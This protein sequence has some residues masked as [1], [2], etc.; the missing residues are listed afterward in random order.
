[1]HTYN[2]LGLMSG[3]SLDGLDMAYCQYRFVQQC[4]EFEIVKTRQ[5]AY[6]DTRRKELAYAVTL[7]A[8]E[9]LGLHHRYGDWLG[10]QVRQFVVQEQLK[11]DFVASHGHTVHHRPDLG[12]TFQAGCGQHLSNRCGLPVVCDF[13]S[14]DLALG[15]QG[16]PLVPMGDRLLFGEYD[17]C[18][19][20]GGISNISF[21]D[22]SQRIAY[23]IG[24]ANMLLNYLCRKIQQPFDPNGDIARSGTCNDELL[25]KLNALPYY[26]SAYPKSTGYEW[27]AKEI[28]PLAE[29]SADTVPNLL[30][31]AVHHIAYTVALAL[32]LH[33]VGRFMPKVLVSGGGAFNT[34]LID[35][36]RNYLQD[37]AEIIIPDSQII[38]YKEALI[39]GFL[40]VLRE[41]KQVNTLHSV[42]GA[43]A[44]SC[45][46]IFYFPQ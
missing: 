28:I 14:S 6:T 5:I 34:F 31:T 7:P 4:W 23:D 36:I 32:K 2:V 11:I 44:D 41:R 3:T 16:A 10:G 22:G 15:G 20:I 46:G 8:V 12:I 42:T 26:K 37:R 24:I 30:C 9:L 19:N 17:F 1:M 43:K 45:G 39:F 40:G 38:D 33:S 35:S 21:E 29:A 13:R 18:L 27:F 25:Q